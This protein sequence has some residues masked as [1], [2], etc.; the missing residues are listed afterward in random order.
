ME[1][2]YVVERNR[3]FDLSFPHGLVSLSDQR[4]T[5]NRYVERIRTHGFF[6]ERRKAEQD[7]RWKQIIPYVVVKQD[8]RILL[9]E[10]KNK[11]GEAR[12]HGKRSIGVGGHVN[13]IDEDSQHVLAA[14]LHREV[15]EELDVGGPYQVKVAGFL[16]D[17][18]TDVGSVHFGM[19]ALLTTSAPVS[20]RETDMM[21]GRLVSP[22]ELTELHQQDPDRFET[23][24]SLLLDRLNDVLKADLDLNA[25]LGA[26]R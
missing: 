3:L 13:P 16:N 12:L 5:V 19:V 14:G 10:R 15:E 6:V 11:Q 9:L 26:A 23:W 1:F 8:D 17:D 21:D 24:S 18:A 7:S 25:A 20:I 4:E 22:Q 2:V